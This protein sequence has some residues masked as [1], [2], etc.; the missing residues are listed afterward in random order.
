MNY[1]DEAATPKDF[2]F[3]QNITEG[4]DPFFLNVNPYISKF[5]L[6]FFRSALPFKTFF[7][8]RLASHVTV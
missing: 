1:Q 3:I 2:V 4:F 6:Q 5:A 7:L 8:G